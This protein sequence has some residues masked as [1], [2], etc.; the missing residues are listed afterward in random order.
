M[1]ATWISNPLSPLFSLCPTESQVGLDASHSRQLFNSLKTGQESESS[2][3]V[4]LKREA[5]PKSEQERES[6]QKVEQKEESESV[7]KL[8]RA[9][10]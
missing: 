3:K 4:E 5:G 2:P 1:R 6:G 10:N 7:Q 9:L 8:S